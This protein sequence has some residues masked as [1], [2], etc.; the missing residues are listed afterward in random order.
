MEN[1]GPSMGAPFCPPPKD[2]EHLLAIWLAS[3]RT[4]SPYPLA[5][6]ADPAPAMAAKLSLAAVLALC[7]A[8]LAHAQNCAYA[9]DACVASNA[10]VASLKGSTNAIDQ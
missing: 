8:G 4:R 3:A 7:A 5:N 1:W 6:P 9:N 10:Y 2:G